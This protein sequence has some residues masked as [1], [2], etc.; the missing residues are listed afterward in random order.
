MLVSLSLEGRA[1]WCAFRLGPVRWHCLLQ[2]AHVK[3]SPCSWFT[4]TLF[5]WKA[6]CAAPGANGGSINV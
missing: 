2:V 5:L 3:R 4:S 1:W 6:G